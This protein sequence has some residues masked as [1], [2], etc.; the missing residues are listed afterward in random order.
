[1]YI[2]ILHFK[3]QN[4]FS[5]QSVLLIYFNYYTEFT[6]EWANLP[7]LEEADVY[8]LEQE[9]EQ[10]IAQHFEG[11]YKYILFQA[12]LFQIINVNIE[13]LNTIQKFDLH[14]RYWSA[15]QIRGGSHRRRKYANISSI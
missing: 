9:S 1:M 6:D 3:F 7:S 8:K 12:K 11:L 5:F 2:E 4:I 14:F 15:E 10:R 13:M